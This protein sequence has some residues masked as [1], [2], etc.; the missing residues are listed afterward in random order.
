MKANELGMG[1]RNPT[2]ILKE[3]LIQR[4]LHTTSM[5]IFILERLRADEASVAYLVIDKYPLG[6]AIL[7]ILTLKILLLR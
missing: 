5:I 1:P 6:K 4:H 7:N 2:L 3:I